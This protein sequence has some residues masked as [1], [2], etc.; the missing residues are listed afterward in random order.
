MDCTVSGAGVCSRAA[1][2][3]FT[4]QSQSHFA[5]RPSGA[6][7]RADLSG[8]WLHDLRHAKQA[9]RKMAGF[10][11]KLFPLDSHSWQG[12]ALSAITK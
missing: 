11:R 8:G 5:L 3:Q 12:A 4:V 2:R 1:I 7:A 10:D 6:V 9:W